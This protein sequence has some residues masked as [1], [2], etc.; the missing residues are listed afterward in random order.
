MANFLRFLRVVGD[1]TKLDVTNFSY[2]Y[3]PPYLKVTKTIKVGCPRPGVIVRVGSFLWHMIRTFASLPRS[4]Q[5]PSVRKGEKLF[6]AVHRNEHSALQPILESFQNSKL[7]GV[8]EVGEK[9][10]LFWAYIY[11]LSFFPLVIFRYFQETP[12]MRE[13]YRYVLDDYWLAY[14]Y[15]IYARQLLANKQP[16]VLVMANDH[17]MWTRALLQAARN[18]KVPTIYVQHASVTTNFPPLA[19]DYALLDGMEAAEK[20]AICGASSTRVYLVGIPKF[21]KYQKFI[22]SFDKVNRVGVCVNPL[23]TPEDLSSLAEVLKQRVSE[24][25]IVLRPHPADTRLASWIAFAQGHG[26]QFSDGRTK[27]AVEFLSNVDAIIA[28]ESNILLEAALMNVVPLY[29]DFFGQN[30]D[31]YGFQKNG[32]VTCYYEPDDVVKELLNLS[33]HKPD[34]RHRAKRFCATIGTRYDGRSQFIAS[35]LIESIAANHPSA[36][37]EWQK[38]EEI[39]EL[40]VYRLVNEAP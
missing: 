7:L 38:V 14:G 24:L 17:L 6:F 9:F 29:Y 28:G 16:S 32:L 5:A 36:P 10:P 20:Y 8:Y 11:A 22:N 3:L 21:D 31:W 1:A 2:M 34:I 39:K 37:E 33:S 18:E 23:N 4:A 35:Q 12:E 13:T 25:Q 19:F 15:Y 27:T 26:W 30:M 40:D